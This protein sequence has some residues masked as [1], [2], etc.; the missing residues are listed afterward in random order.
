[1]KLS[2]VILAAG[3]G[4][5]LCSTLPKVLH[6][7]AGK[8]LLT[9]V[10]ETAQQL[11]P[12]AILVVYGYGGEQV[13]TQLQALPVQWV[14]QEEQWGTAHAVAQALPSIPSDHAVLVLLGD[15]PL[16]SSASLSTLI[17]LMDADSVGMM[18]ARFPDPQGF[19]RILRSDAGEVIAVVEEK[20]AHDGQRLINEVN[21]GIFLVYARDLARWIPQINNHN[22]QQEYY[23]PDIIPLAVAEKRCI[24]T[25]IPAAYQEVQGINTR[26]Q[27]AALERYWQVK[28]ATALQ[29]KGVS[30]L[31]PNRFDL[32][33]Q[34]TIGTDVTIDVNVIIEGDVVIGDDC[35]I[36]PHSLLRNVVL[37][38]GVRVES[39][40]VLDGATVGDRCKIGPFA[41]LRPETVLETEVHVGNFVET[42]KTVIG[43]G[44][45]AN[46]LTY[47]GD[48]TI[49]Q[50][51]N[52]GAGTITCN[53]NGVNKFQTI[54]GD[55][56]F[57]GSNTALV[58]PV[59]IGADATIGAG[60]TITRKAPAERL[61]LSRSQEVTIEHWR[62]PSKKDS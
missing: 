6:P 44:S 3:H 53:Y 62:R 11:N 42:K 57:I 52:I 17:A 20:D 14:R 5:R 43:S 4:Q 54:I 10:V 58:A 24:V 41:R 21:T 55:G 60:S 31:D 35:Y 22:A 56:A 32:R 7:L 33:G 46:H 13:P 25:T 48:A 39:H 51:V 61:T 15:V 28:T 45:K 18:T 12:A 47:L 38:A 29:L 30:V 37:G 9:H 50:R 16:V 34:L 23:L 36:G 2:I 1:M 26:A 8:P 19:G 27:L 40:S 49:G 59:E